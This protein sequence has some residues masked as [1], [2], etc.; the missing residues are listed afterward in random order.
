[1]A[2]P[3]DPITLSTVWH[4]FQS[5][6]K[7]MRYV[8]DRTSQNY[9]IAQLHDVSVGIW[10]GAGRTVAVPIG[11]SVQYLGGKL[12]VQYVLEKFRGKLGPGD[13]ILVND[14][15][16]GHCCHLPDWGFYRPIFYR[17]ELLF[18][19]FC[20]AHQM[21]TGGAYPGGYFPNAYDIHA[22]GLRIP[23]IKVM[24]GDR[25]REDVME[26][27]LENVRWPEGTRIDNYAQIAATRLC[28]QRVVALLDK[29]GKDTVLAAVEEMMARTE[30]AVRA[31]IEKIPDGT[32]DGEAA[33]DDDGTELDVP[34]WARCEIT[35]RG[36]TL[37]V[38]F[39]KSDPQ[40]K[41]FVNC[42]FAST[43]SNTLSALFMFLDPA[44]AEYHNEGSLR[45]I[46]VYAP[47]G[48]VL[49]ARYP[50]TVGASPVSMGHQIIEAV[51]SAMS[52]AVPE[53]AIACWGKRYGHYI[54]GNDPRTGEKYVVTTFD[55][56]GGAGA[57]RGHDGYEGA[58]SIGALGEV[59]R[60]NV[61]EIELRFPWRVR[62]WEFA[63]DTAGAGEWR[64]A[65]GIHW[66]VENVGGEAGIATGSSDGEIV[67]APG[68]LGG[69]PTP[70]SRSWLIR[71][72]ERRPIRG[73][74]LYQLEPG[75]VIVKI[76]GGGAGVG[77]PARR[78]AEKV[79]AD[80]VNG[81]VSIE[82]AREV[83]RVAIDPET[84][85]IDRRSTAALRATAKPV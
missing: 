31:A 12:S 72:Q 83:Y 30:K 54:F 27:I 46:T 53:R 85:E 70:N 71:G 11:L 64:G 69:E 49:N 38:D 28:E 24:E 66:E 8:I 7:E 73:H 18:F 56:D 62:R 42:V 16:D 82:K 4:S 35:I 14:P 61:E 57:V 36:D 13:V 80:V 47:P 75:D 5:I 76:S 10:D 34:V 55:T 2:G 77:D 50:A 59:N 29:Y 41:G 81:F 44:L 74:R 26:L 68:A 43:Y 25:E 9:L 22:E 39:S 48:S 20:R 6:C 58:T 3:I 52:K 32:Y 78:D 37:R 17:G 60:G 63:E 33:T 15:Y 51:A 45:P 79:R 40:R 21:D 19:T 84:L 1:M 67:R 65:S 23:G